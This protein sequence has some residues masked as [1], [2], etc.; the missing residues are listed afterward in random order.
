[1]SKVVREEQNLAQRD[2]LVYIQHLEEPPEKWI[3]DG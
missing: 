3:S 1:M 2:Q